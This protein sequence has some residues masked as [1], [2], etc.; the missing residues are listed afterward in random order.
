[1]FAGCIGGPVRQ[2]SPAGALDGAQA[3]T[4]AG[5]QVYASAFGWGAGGLDALSHFTIAGFTTGNPPG[6]PEARPRPCL[7][8][9]S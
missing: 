5:N 9:W 1:V 6:G 7:F 3:V 8:A 2:P 4:V